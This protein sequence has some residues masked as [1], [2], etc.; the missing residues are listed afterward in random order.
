MIN[1]LPARVAVALGSAAISLA[2]CGGT[3]AA[4]EY[5][6]CAP[7]AEALPTYEVTNVK[8][9]GSSDNFEHGPDWKV[10]GYGPGTLALAKSVEAS[11]S[12]SVSSDVSVSALSAAVGFDVTETVSYTASFEL[13]IPAEPPNHRWFIEAGTRDDHY[14]YDVQKYCLGIPDGAP[15]RGRAEKSG[16]LIYDYYSQA[17]GN[18]RK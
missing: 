12:Y 10:A 6:P 14:M 18:P 16:H 9:Y 15:V 17:P 13:D 8:H 7:G 5:D 2:V 3:A 11:H 4:Q 1:R